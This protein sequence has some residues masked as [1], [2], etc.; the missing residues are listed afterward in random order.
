MSHFPW[1]CDCSTGT[2]VRLNHNYIKHQEGLSFQSEKIFGL[3][4]SF[5]TLTPRLTCGMAEGC[6]LQNNASEFAWEVSVHVA[7]VKKQLR[8]A[9]VWM[10]NWTANLTYKKRR[11]TKINQGNY[12]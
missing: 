9:E 10:E 7:R 11:E 3:S 8:V 1:V 4:S 2:E 6:G 12:F 5:P